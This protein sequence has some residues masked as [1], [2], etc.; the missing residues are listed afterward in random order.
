[1]EA[2]AL[3]CSLKKALLRI[4][5]I[6]LETP[7]L[8]SPFWY[9]CIPEA[10]CFPGVFQHRCFPVKFVKLFEKSS[11]YR[12]FLVDA[13]DLRNLQLPQIK[14]IHLTQ[15]FRV[16][17]VFDVIIRVKIE[18]SETSKISNFLRKNTFLGIYK[19]CKYSRVLWVFDFS[20]MAKIE[21]SETSEIFQL[22]QVKQ[23]PWNLQVL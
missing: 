18:N 2:L 20:I 1:M 12:T 3:R 8:E 15:K 9:I 19:C 13:S 16:F 23:I 21:N 22:R 10:W 6:A 11:S 14:Q 4:S 17:G 7:V 5:Q